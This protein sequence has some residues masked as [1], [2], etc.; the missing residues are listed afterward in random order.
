MAGFLRIQNYP[1][2]QPKES[3]ALEGAP[4]ATAPPQSDDYTARLMKLLPAPVVALYL[5][6]SN[7]TPTNSTLGITTLI[8]WSIICL[9]LVVLFTAA[10]TTAPE[11]R[12]GPDWIHVAIACISFLIWL[13]AIGGPFAAFHIAVGFI[14]SL[15][16]AG[17]TF[18]IP[19]VY[20]GQPIAN[21]R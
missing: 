20:K 2:A 12:Q 5:F 18:I 17:W 14:A 10:F 3:I 13:Y 11:A 1:P 7:V 15:L 21:T 6:G 19:Y 4:Q 8:V 9:G 16:V